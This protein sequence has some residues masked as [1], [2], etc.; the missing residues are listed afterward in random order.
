MLRELY[1][2]GKGRLAARCNSL[3]N[4]RAGTGRAGTGKEKTG[5]FSGKQGK[6]GVNFWWKRGKVLVE[7][8]QSFGGKGVNFWSE[9]N[10]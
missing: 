9:K 8:G 6:K 2:A 4:A 5:L 7:K 3:K 1:R 10:F